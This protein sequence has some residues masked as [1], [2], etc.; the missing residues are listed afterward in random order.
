MRVVGW[1]C[2]VVEEDGLDDLIRCV[3]SI[4]LALCFQGQSSRLSR[5]GQAP[6][7]IGAGRQAD[8]GAGY[9]CA[10]GCGGWVGL[11][12]GEGVGHATDHGADE[13]EET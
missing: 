11:E 12:E 4:D 9:G 3:I 1:R 13:G 5:T 10:A 8:T 7:S 6:R 2:A